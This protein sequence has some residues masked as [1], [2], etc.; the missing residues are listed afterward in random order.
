MTTRKSTPTRKH[1]GDK[2]NHP[3]HY[4]QGRIEVIEA[5]EDWNLG[6]HL[7]NVVKYVARSKYKGDE[8]G[9]LQKA[10]WYLQRH[11]EGMR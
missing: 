8:A 7:G 11:I 5:I 2:I 1:R 6:Y 10:A 9:D 4:T 3:K